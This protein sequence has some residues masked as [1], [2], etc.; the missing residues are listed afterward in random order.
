MIEKDSVEMAAGTDVGAT[1]RRMDRPWH[2]QIRDVLNREWNPIGSCPGDEYRTY[3]DKI[4]A[5]ILLGASDDDLMRYLEWA[6][7]E[8]MGLSPFNIVRARN[9]IDAIRAIARG[10]RG[11]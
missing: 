11:T 9:S 5:M 1:A 4:A 3:S 10:H 6:E 7:V 8:Q 2:Q